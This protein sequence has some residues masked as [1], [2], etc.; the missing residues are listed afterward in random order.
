MLPV[1]THVLLR[2]HTYAN[3]LAPVH[4]NCVIDIYLFVRC[5]KFVEVS[6][7]NRRRSG[8]CLVCRFQVQNV[9][10]N[11]LRTVRIFS[12]V[13]GGVRMFSL[14]FDPVQV[15][16]GAVIAQS[17]QQLATGWTAWG[18]N[19]GGRA[20][21]YASV[22]TGPGVRL[23]PYTM[24]TGSWPGVKRPGRCVDYP[25]LSSA[26]VKGRV[27]LYICSPSGPSWPVLG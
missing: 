21:F 3:A 1:V 25:P 18:S 20:R 15:C 9:A 11:C 13:H 2:Q 4:Q 6:P 10:A 23:A 12:G 5:H 19:P 7:R 14:G 17:V 27:E 8:T 16:R 26:E 24:G 22:Q